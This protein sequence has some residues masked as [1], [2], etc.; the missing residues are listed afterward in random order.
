MR[1]DT[2]LDTFNKLPWHD[3]RLLR[4]VIEA[5]SHGGHNIFFEVE[6]VAGQAASIL[7]L[8]DCTIVQ[9]DLDLDAKTVC[10]DSIWSAVCNRDTPLKRTLTDGRLASESNPLKDYLHFRITFI[11][12]GGEINAFAKGYELLESS[13][14]GLGTR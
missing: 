5:N 14:L 2:E 9:M 8:V 4:I 1:D 13:Q 6:F 7:T 12:T 3:A 11:P 10:G